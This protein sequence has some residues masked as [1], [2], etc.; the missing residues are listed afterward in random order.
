MVEYGYL[1]DEPDIGIFRSRFTVDELTELDRLRGQEASTIVDEYISKEMYRTFLSKYSVA[2]DPYLHEV[3]VHLFRRNRYLNRAQLEPVE[4]PHHYNVSLRENQFLEKYFPTT[5]RNSS[6]VWST[7]T[8]AQ[9]EA[10]ADQGGQYETRVSEALITRIGE[11]Q[12]LAGL[13]I[14][15]LGLTLMAIF[16][17]MRRNS[18]WG[19]SGE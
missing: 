19:G 6:H 12:A 14:G 13:S 2:R 1:Y 7:T 15:V 4:A 5:L 10:G 3:G 11:A 18:T 17:T 9:V 8:L 16:F